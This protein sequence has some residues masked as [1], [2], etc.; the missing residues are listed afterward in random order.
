MRKADRPRWPNAAAIDEPAG[1][2]TPGD[3]VLRGEQAPLT[4][5]VKL[6]NLQEQT[7]DAR[8]CLSNAPAAACFSNFRLSCHKDIQ[9][10]NCNPFFRF[11]SLTG[12]T[13]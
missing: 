12:S 1:N 6:G 10:D 9:T 7:G 2:L 4:G 13:L 8:S 5:S 3:L 11:L